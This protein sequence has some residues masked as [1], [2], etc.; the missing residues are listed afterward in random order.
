MSQLYS[1]HPNALQSSHLINGQPQHPEIFPLIFQ[2]N[3]VT[4]KLS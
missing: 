2:S 1:V 4:I 3:F